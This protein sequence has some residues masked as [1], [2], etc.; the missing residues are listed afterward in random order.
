MNGTSHHHHHHQPHTHTHT[1]KSNN[2]PQQHNM[3]RID[4]W[5][6]V[7][8]DSVETLIEIFVQEKGQKRGVVFFV[9]LFFDDNNDGK[10]ESGKYT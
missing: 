5:I 9:W 3:L 6:A 8:V 2:I 4:K 7:V 10:G 1:Q